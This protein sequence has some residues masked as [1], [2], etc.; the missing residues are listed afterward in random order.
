MMK[1]RVFG[2]GTT[3]SILVSPDRLKGRQVRRTRGKGKKEQAK[4]DLKDPEEHSLVKNKDRTQNG[5]QK[6]IVLG[7]P[8]EREARKVFFRRVM[9][10]FRKVVF[11]LA[12][13]K[14][15]QGM[16]SNPHK[17]RGKDQ[18]GK[19]KEGGLS[20]IWTFSLGNTQ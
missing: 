6:K 19:G 15:V 12:N 2:H 14:R 10:A 16:I 17:G 8:K 4:V 1:N 20:S 3:T 9:K 13:Q 18:K 5:G 11:A 7:G